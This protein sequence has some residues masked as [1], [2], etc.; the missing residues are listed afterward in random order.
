MHHFFR[1]LCSS[2]PSVDFGESLGGEKVGAL[3]LARRGAAEASGSLRSPGGTG[4]APHGGHP[5]GGTGDAPAI[6]WAIPQGVKISV[7][8]MA[9]SVR[10]QLI[11]LMDERNG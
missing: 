9:V 3:C 2:G 6:R 10:S 8:K 5:M 11:E 7:E 1:F 4:G